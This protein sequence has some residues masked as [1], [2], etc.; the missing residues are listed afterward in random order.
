MHFITRM[1]S[2]YYISS[3]P[4]HSCH[5]RDG[6]SNTPEHSNHIYLPNSSL[7]GDPDAVA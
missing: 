6:V 3:Y 4:P 7:I 1:Y 2:L 5:A